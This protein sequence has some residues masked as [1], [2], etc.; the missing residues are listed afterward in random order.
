MSVNTPAQ[1]PDYDLD[2]MLVVSAREQLRALADDLRS[3]LLELVLERAGPSPSW[4]WPSTGPRA[5]GLPRQPAVDA[6]LLKVVRTQRVRAIEERYYGRVARTIYIGALSSDEDIALVANVDGVATA[7]GESR[8]ARMPTNSAARWSTRASRSRRCARSGPRCRARGKFAQIPGPVTR[9]TASS[10][11]S[12]PATPRPCRRGALMREPFAH[13]HGY[14]DLRRQ[15]SA[16]RCGHRGVLWVGRPRAAVPAGG[17][18]HVRRTPRRDARGPRPLRVRARRRGA[19][20]ERLV[21]A[22]GRGV[23][24]VRAAMRQTTP[25][26][27][28]RPSDPDSNSARSLAA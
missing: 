28:S 11:A 10:P 25:R 5:R 15:A 17:A 18:L 27:S 9:S 6:G 12:T 2:E 8:R 7:Y 4:P 23:A 13:E 24:D 26:D 21:G 19:V 22:L 14:W 3:T 20:R 16:R 1:I